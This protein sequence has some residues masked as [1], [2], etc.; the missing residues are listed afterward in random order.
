MKRIVKYIFIITALFFISQ[1]TNAQCKNFAKQVC[2]KELTPYIHDGNYNAAIL[3]EGEDA[4][5]YKTFY[6][7]QD[8]R[9][10]ICYSDAL[11]TIHLKVMDIN[12][13]VLFDNAEFDY[14]NQWD[15][16][17]NSTQQLIIWLEVGTFDESVD[18]NIDLASGCVAILFGLLEL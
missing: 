2:K 11:P 18:E 3:S 12:R 17:P 7:G 5:L 6:A 9:V 16:K 8:Y 14:T 4:E 1:H 13:N 10:L 15:F